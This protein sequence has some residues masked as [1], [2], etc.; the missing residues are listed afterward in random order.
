MGGSDTINEERMRLIARRLGQ[1]A[2]I[3]RVDTFPLEKPDPD[4]Y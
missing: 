3:Q 2:F 4:D 1:Q